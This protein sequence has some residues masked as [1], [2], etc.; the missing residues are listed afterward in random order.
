MA[1]INPELLR[2]FFDGKCTSAEVHQVLVWINSEEGAIDLGI[3]LEK[4][5][6]EREVN[7]STSQ[8]MLAKIHQ[9][10]SEAEGQLLP[11][12]TGNVRS[13]GDPAKP[14]SGLFNQW[15]LGIAVSFLLTIM[16][17]AIWLFS[18]RRDENQREPSN[19]AQAEYLTRQ[20]RSGEKL[21]LK[22]NDGT[23][24][25]INSNSKVRFPKAFT[26]A[27][28]EVYM[29]GQVFFEVKR[30][31]NK[32]FIVHSSG[33]ITSVLGTSFAIMEDSATQRSQ[34]AVLTGK[35]KVAM[36]EEQG[37][38]ESES[39]YLNPMD[40]ATLDALEGSLEKI[41]VDYDEVFAWKDNVI[42]F[43]NATFEEV[44]IRLEKWF[45]VEFLMKKKINPIKEFTGKFDDQTLEEIL[46]G[47]SFTYDFDFTINDSTVVI[48]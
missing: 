30:D 28:R 2:K 39:L 38:K 29:E 15:K 10:I 20:T 24:I 1:S 44:Q 46:I 26:G 4:F 11:A 42:V 41:K 19:S 31:E 36:A 13:L 34:V 35:V 14:E 8:D 21:T 33:L 9:R 32:P 43:Q 6:D 27:K 5:E 25:R 40:A 18:G 47:L 48:R 17:S 16:A 7:S 37:A 3:H 12:E 23:V 45:G 22:L